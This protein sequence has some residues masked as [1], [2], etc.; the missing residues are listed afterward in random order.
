MGSIVWICDAVSICAALKCNCNEQI[1]C[2][3]ANNRLQ[4]AGRETPAF[5]YRDGVPC[6]LQRFSPKRCDVQTDLHDVTTPE[7]DRHSHRCEDL[8]SHSLFT[9]LTRACHRFTL[10]IKWIHSKTS[11]PIFLRSVLILCSHVAY[12]CRV[13]F[14]LQASYLTQTPLATDD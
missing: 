6:G 7:E 13:V 12:F 9:V 10:G 1:R 4:L 2:S 14:Y 11:E 8:N 3:E 5:Y